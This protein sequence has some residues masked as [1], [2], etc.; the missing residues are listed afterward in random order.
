MSSEEATE[1]EDGE[2]VAEYVAEVDMGKRTR[3]QEPPVALADIIEVERHV[4]D[5]M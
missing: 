1:E 5:E 3:E 4:A 2:Q